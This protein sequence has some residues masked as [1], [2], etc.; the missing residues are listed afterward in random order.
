MSPATEQLLNAVLTLPEEERIELVE[1]LLASEDTPGELPFDSK[2]LG[3]FQT[4]SAE[5]EAGTVE[6]IPWPLVREQAR[7]RLVDRSSD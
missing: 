1:A 2:W 7:H 6:L 5:V 3:E 4:R